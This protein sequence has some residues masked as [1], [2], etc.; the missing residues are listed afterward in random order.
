[1]SIVYPL[2]APLSAR[3]TSA[4]SMALATGIALASIAACRMVTNVASLD[5]SELDGLVFLAKAYWMVSAI[6]YFAPRS[7]K[8]CSENLDCHG[9]EPRT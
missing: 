6:G 5:H 9:T 1:M 7:V 8:R 4:L 2:R 3:R